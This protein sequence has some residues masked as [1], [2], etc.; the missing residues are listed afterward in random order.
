MHTHNI[1]I[2]SDLER[3]QLVDLIAVAQAAN[4]AMQFDIRYASTDN[5]TGLAVY[6][7]PRAFIRVDAAAALLR[8]TQHLSS[9]GYGL[10]VFDAYRPWH[11][12]LYFWVNFPNDRLYLAN[13]SHGSRH[14]RGCAIDLTLY[15]LATGEEVRMP[16]AYDEFNEKAHLHYAGGSASEREARELLQ[17]AMLAEG[18]SSHPHEWWHFDYQNWQRCAVL[19]DSFAMLDALLHTT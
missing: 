16:S 9:F 11:V 17:T 18:F 8:A 6:D 12:T 5:F 7:A 14:N 19:D 4:V 13:P 3:A 1:P 15:E 2:E 10:R